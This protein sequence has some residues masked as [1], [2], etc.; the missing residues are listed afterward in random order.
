MKNFMLSSAQTSLEFFLR[1]KKFLL[2]FIS[3]PVNFIS[4]DNSYRNRTPS[5][6]DIFFISRQRVIGRTNGS[7]AYLL[8]L[9]DAAKGAGFTPH[10]LQPSPDIMGRWPVMRLRPEMSV[11]HS[12]EIRSV[13]KLGSWVISLDPGV[14]RDAI[15]A[16]MIR[17]FRRAGLTATWLKDRPRPYSIAAA[18]RNSDRS[19]V[20]RHARARADLVIA[21]YAFQAEAL[22][23]LPDLPGAIVMHDLFHRRKIASGGRDSVCYLDRDQEIALLRRADAVLAIQADEAGFVSEH[24]PVARTILAPMAVRPVEAAQPGATGRLL[25]VGSNTAP[26]V[27][28]L[29]WFFENVWPTVRSRSPETTL[30]VVGSVALAFPGRAPE[31]VRFHGII[32]DL[33]SIYAAAAVVISP[34]TFGSGLKIKLVEAMAQGKAVVATSVT[35]QGVEHECRPVIRV[36]DEAQAFAEA[37]LSLEDEQHRLALGTAAL[38]AART[39]FSPQVCHAA[40]IA[41]LEDNRPDLDADPKVRNRS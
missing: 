27:V 23:L 14:F 4:K 10:L 11:F 32:D 41:W 33:A 37:V 31:G 40:F 12:H 24:V 34:L 6:G 19:F 1:P 3:F 9:A 2:D 21:D 20:I 5:K 39:H 25:F 28:C 26:N 38:S 30:D 8:D 36:A 35:L 22:D 15:L 17:W 18:W 7:S 29:E 16:I 13:L